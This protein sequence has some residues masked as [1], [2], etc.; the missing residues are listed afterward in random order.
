[1]M[2]RLA[3]ACRNTSVRRT[4]GTALEPMMS[5]NTCPGPM[6]GSW[7]VSPTTSSAAGFVTLPCREREVSAPQELSGRRDSRPPRGHRDTAKRAV[8]LGGDEMALDVEGIVDGG[9]CGEKFLG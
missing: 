5:A 9:V 4:T 3:A 7:S 6:E 8:R 2:I 1:M